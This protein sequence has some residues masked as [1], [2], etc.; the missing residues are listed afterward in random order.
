MTAAETANLAAV[1]SIYDAF[2]RGDI[3]AIL[4][5][6]ADDVDWE[7]DAIDHGVPWLKP[8][9][10]R[11][12][13]ADFFLSLA[14]YEI[15]RFE[16]NGFFAGGDRVVATIAVEAAVRATGRPIKD[17]EV[18]LWTFGPDGKVSRFRHVLDTHQQ[19]MACRT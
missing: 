10:G 17:L 13:V 8:G 3:P 6:M 11:P 15:H 4:A 19:V 7:H 16:P 14:G 5:Y 2:G 12:H 18:H 9:R 1:K